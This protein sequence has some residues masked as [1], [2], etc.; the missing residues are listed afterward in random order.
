VGLICDQYLFRLWMSCWSPDAAL[1]SI[2]RVGLDMACAI[3]V[4]CHITPSFGNIVG[5]YCVIQIPGSHKGHSHMARH[6]ASRHKATVVSWFSRW[7]NF[8]Y[9]YVQTVILLLVLVLKLMLIQAHRTSI[10]LVKQ[11][12]LFVIET[13]WLGDSRFSAQFMVKNA[14]CFSDIFHWKKQWKIQVFFTFFELSLEF[15][16]LNS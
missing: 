12:A 7:V 5:R 16:T 11:S 2:D 10:V 14:V 4:D 1:R 9:S 8:T 3:W 6:T 15:F 13:H